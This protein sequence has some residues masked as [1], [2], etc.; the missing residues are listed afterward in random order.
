MPQY[1]L[2]LLPEA[3]HPTQVWPT[4]YSPGYACPDPVKSAVVQCLRNMQ[5][6]RNKGIPIGWAVDGANRHDS[7]LF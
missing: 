6:L 7:I 4:S 2:H 5:C 1:S 3:T